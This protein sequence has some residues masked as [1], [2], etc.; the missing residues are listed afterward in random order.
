MKITLYILL[1]ILSLLLCSCGEP[2]KTIRPVCP[3]KLNASLAIEALQKNQKAGPFRAY[4][5]CLAA[6][7]S[8]GKKKKDTFNVKLWYNTEN[9]FRFFGSM[10][11]NENAI[12]AGSNKDFFWLALKPK[13]LG[14]N[15][16]WG[17]WKNQGQY[18]YLKISPKLLLEAMGNITFDKSSQWILSSEK[19]YDILSLSQNGKLKKRLH[20]Y[21]CNYELSKIEYFGD[22][23]DLIASVEMDKYKELGT[24]FKVPGKITLKSINTDNTADTFTITFKNLNLFSFDEK[25]RQNIFY[26]KPKPEQFKNIY[27]LIDGDF[28][29]ER[30]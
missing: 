13:E 26:K 27:R 30:F 12:D 22:N 6:Y 2:A 8:E 7:Y 10:P 23:S 4:G 25:R 9:E 15:Y 19:G 18:M 14:N 21:N 3:G 11:F 16:F 29:E 17:Q 20:I 28:V 5:D 24:D 1:L